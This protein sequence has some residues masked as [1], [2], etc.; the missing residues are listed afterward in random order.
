MTPSFLPEPFARAFHQRNIRPA[1]WLKLDVAKTIIFDLGGVLVH[2]DWDQVC[3][4][5]ET[6]S[7]RGAGAVRAEVVNGPIVY[8]SMR[9][10]IGAQEF[11]QRLCDRLEIKISYEAF[12]EIWNGLL[13]PNQEIVPL[14]EGLKPRHKLVLA[15]N[16]DTIHFSYS[17]KHFPV[18]CQFE[19]HFLSYEMGLLKPETAFFDHVLRALDAL[20]GDC[21]FIDDRS[22]NVDAARRVGITS[23]PF[24]NVERLQSDLNQFL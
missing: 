18:L 4:A 17:I 20:P 16:T 1:P 3:G 15:S 5:L 14:V 21:V 6:L 7:T 13:R 11:Q 12:V 19:R 8:E 2:L 23:F 9:G 10:D 22:D 24:D